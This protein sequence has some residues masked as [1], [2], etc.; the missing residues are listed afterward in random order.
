MPV[1]VA[2]DGYKL[3]Y[4]AVGREDTPA[5]V[6]PA[7][8][9]AEFAAL[10]AALADRYRVVRYKPRQ[11]VGEMEAEEEAAGPPPGPSA[12]P[13]VGTPGR[14]CGSDRSARPKVLW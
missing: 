8:F 1:A 7:R 12:V 11:V 4:D 9:R 13:G 14:P 10:G 2:A 5:L 6:F 3:W